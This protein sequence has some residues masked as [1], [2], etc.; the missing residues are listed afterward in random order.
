MQA[1]SP[2][3]NNYILMK[4]IKKQVLYAVCL[5]SLLS[6]SCDKDP[7]QFDSPFELGINESINLPG[8]GTIITLKSIND[9]RCPANA[10]CIRAG[11]AL[12]KLRMTDNS[13]E[14]VFGELCIGFCDTKMQEEDSIVIRLNKTSY[15]V[16]LK[17][18]SPYPG[19]ESTPDKKAS[20]LIRKE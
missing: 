18:V 15:T 6:T 5:L 1:S 16:I 3:K 11:N 19:T 17:S 13:G 14:E 4:N 10:Y 9:S 8:N 7:I 20:L 12:V 2:L